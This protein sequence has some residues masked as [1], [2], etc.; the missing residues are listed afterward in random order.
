MN[1]APPD[2]IAALRAALALSEARAEAAEAEAARVKAHA[3]NAEAL[4]AEAR[5]KTQRTS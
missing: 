4:I 3:S 1:A 5:G 2:D